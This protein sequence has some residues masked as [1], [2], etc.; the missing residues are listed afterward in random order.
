MEASPPGSGF[1]DAHFHADDL[2]RVAPGE[3]AA[4]RGLGIVGLASAHDPEAWGLSKKLSAERGPWLSTFGI[5]PQAPSME[6][7]DF[8]SELAATGQL[9][10]I[11][12]CGFDYYGDQALRTRGGEGERLQRQAFEFQLGLA[13]EYGLPLV[14]HLRRSTDELFRYARELARLPALILHSWVG[15]ANEALDFLARVPRAKFSFGT[16]ILNGNRKASSSA[17]N[18][19]SESILTETDA[20]FQPPRAS[21]LPHA[22]LLRGHSTFSDLPR[23]VQTLA[24]LRSEDAATVQSA[25]ARNFTEVFAHA[26]QRA[27]GD[28]IRL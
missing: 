11:G 23:I 14:L 5:H 24:E 16:S 6:H 20:P 26:L 27:D 15:P 2:Y 3:L 28:S 21:A 17:A 18:L 7:A 19:P 9:A 4:Y 10:A 8:L 25:V 1:V 12:E 22:P 13:R